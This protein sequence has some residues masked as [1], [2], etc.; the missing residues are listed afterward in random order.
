MANGKSKLNL[1]VIMAENDS[2]TLK[3]R[4]KEISSISGI[5][6]LLLSGYL[7][8]GCQVVAKK[9]T[10]LYFLFKKGKKWQ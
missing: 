3:L 7:R 5:T 10:T 8:Q 2:S 4:I 9:E 1:S 6:I